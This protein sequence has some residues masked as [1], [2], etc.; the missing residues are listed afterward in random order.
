MKEETHLFLHEKKAKLNFIFLTFTTWN[1]MN[2][3]FQVRSQD[4]RE[5]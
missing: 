3:V 5:K 1:S 2:K 4:S